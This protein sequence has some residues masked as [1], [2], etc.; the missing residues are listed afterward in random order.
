M[1]VAGSFSVTM[2]TGVHSAATLT[3][4]K[5]LMLLQE[6][7]DKPYQLQTNTGQTQSFIDWLRDQGYGLNGLMVYEAIEDPRQVFILIKSDD[8]F[9][10]VH[11]VLS[12]PDGYKSGDILGIGGKSAPNP[13]FI[14]TAMSLYQRRL[15]KGHGIRVVAKKDSGM[16]P[17]YQKIINRIVKKSDG[18]HIAGPI[19]QN[20]V[21]IDGVPSIAQ[22]IK[23]KGKFYEWFKT[24]KPVL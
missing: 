6:I 9:W 1:I 22:T 18:G 11:H 19:D 13:R 17:T 14:S 2:R 10:E 5:Y 8:G 16:W 4:T 3:S 24:F 23:N 21:S 20:F 15:D 12:T 7:F